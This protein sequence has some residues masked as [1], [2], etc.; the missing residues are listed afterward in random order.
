[1][2]D[3]ASCGLASFFAGLGQ[4]TVALPAQQFLDH[5]NQFNSARVICRRSRYARFLVRQDRG[6]DILRQARV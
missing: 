3:C 6:R 2:F 4:P 1:L 5:A